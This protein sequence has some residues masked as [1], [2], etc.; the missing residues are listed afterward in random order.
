MKMPAVRS[1]LV[2]FLFPC[3]IVRA[4]LG[5]EK[6]KPPAKPLLKDLIGING[7]FNFKPE[8]YK[9]VCRLARNYHNFEWDVKQP[10]DKLTF[11]VCVNR[12]DWK[13]DVYGKWVKEGFENDICAQFGSFGPHN[14]QYKDL[15]KGKEQWA[16]AYGYEMANQPFLRNDP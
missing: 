16:R 4:A 15:W 9:Q 6:A 10:G 11:P 12:V 7:H 2:L 5:A 1:V 3:L 14:R 8:L 13:R